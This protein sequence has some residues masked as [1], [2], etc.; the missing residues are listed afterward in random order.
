MTEPSPGA[1]ERIR[2][3]AEGRSLDRTLMQECNELRKVAHEHEAEIERLKGRVE[4]LTD[5]AERLTQIR[6][7]DNDRIWEMDKWI[8][9]ESERMAA[10]LERLAEEFAQRS[11]EIEV[12][13]NAEV[14]KGSTSGFVRRR[15]F[16]TLREV[17]SRL[18]ER[19]AELRRGE[20]D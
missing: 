3:F 7:G 11:A 4:D 16:E 20:D 15:H 12:E 17:A 2:V 19:A 14:L 10:E 1:A 13:F 5:R 9:K 8:E 6:R 18:R